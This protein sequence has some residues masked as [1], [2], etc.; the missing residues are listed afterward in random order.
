MSPMVIFLIGVG[1]VALLALFTWTS[2]HE[3]LKGEQEAIDEATTRAKRASAPPPAPA[4]A[5]PMRILVA[6]DGSPC[7]EGA[8]E[9]VAS[10][11]WP[12]G[13]QIEIATVIHTRL[14]LVPDPFLGGAAAHVTALEEDRQR[15]PERVRW[16]E[17]ALGQLRGVTLSSTILEG[18]PAHA[19]LEE[20]ARWQPDLIVVGSHGYG[21]AESV[22]LGSVSQALAHQA[23]CSVEI[24]RCA[25]SHAA[26]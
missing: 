8:L 16:A 13:S 18:V 1:A 15:A 22:L 5:R 11:P 24:I 4:V 26:A 6:T 17:Q 3:V 2:F 19:L 14:P 25:K 21:A 20:A 10:R 23:P 12:D 7:S 9:H